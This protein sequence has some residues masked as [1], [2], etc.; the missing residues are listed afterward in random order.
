[1]IER[2]R[3]SSCSLTLKKEEELWNTDGYWEAHIMVVVLDTDLHFGCRILR[4]DAKKKARR[5][6]EN[7]LGLLRRRYAS[8][9]TS[10]EEYKERKA[11]LEGENKDLL[12]PISDKGVRQ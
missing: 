11:V 6:R 7:P 8:G 9:E 5:L 3:K 1:M 10:T 4:T 2:V 12:D